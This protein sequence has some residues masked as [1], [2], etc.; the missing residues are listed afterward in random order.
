MRSLRLIQMTAARDQFIEDVRH[1]VEASERLETVMV[2]FSTSTRAGLDD[3]SS[4]MSVSESFRIRDSATWSRKVSELL[5]DFE[6]C[7]RQ[8]RA[9]AAAILQEEGMSITEVGRAFGVSH[10]LA[11]RFAK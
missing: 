4:G 2:S 10:Q 8:A 6:R 7:R 1:Y 5:D 11:S 3:L 9:S